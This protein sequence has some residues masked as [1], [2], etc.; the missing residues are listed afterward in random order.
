MLAMHFKVSTARA[1]VSHLSIRAWCSR[2]CQRVC[3]NP[4]FGLRGHGRLL[5]EVI[6]SGSGG[7]AA[8]PL[9]ALSIVGHA[10]L[11]REKLDRCDARGWE[12]RKR[13]QVTTWHE[14]WRPGIYF[15]NLRWQR[16]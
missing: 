6:L 1:M 14:T 10:P 15:H 3:L 16:A 9:L 7:V 13:A 8:L 2:L 11:C 4:L 5:S 12:N